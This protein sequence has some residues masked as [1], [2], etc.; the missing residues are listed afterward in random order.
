MHSYPKEKGFLTWSTC[1]SCSFRMWS[2]KSRAGHQEMNLFYAEFSQGTE[3]TLCQ[4]Q[5]RIWQTRSA[6]SQD[7]LEHILGLVQVPV[8]ASQE[9]PRIW[10][11]L[12]SFLYAKGQS[13][14]CRLIS[15]LSCLSFPGMFKRR[16]IS[17]DWGWLSMWASIT[18]IHT[19]C[20]WWDPWWYSMLSFTV[21]IPWLVLLHTPPA[22]TKSSS[23]SLTD[24]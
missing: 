24:Q 13:W 18:D 9:S 16:F 12:P 7:C 20:W 23:S 1:L 19:Q 15:L 5:N 8:N 11:H 21:Y 3:G 2:P 22:T 10:Q 4:R 17:R 6:L 14:F